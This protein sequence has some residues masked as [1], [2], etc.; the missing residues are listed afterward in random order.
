MAEALPLLSLLPGAPF[1]LLPLLFG[2]A[3][4]LSAICTPP[5]APEDEDLLPPEG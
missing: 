4:V 1:V 5:T 3:P 2:L